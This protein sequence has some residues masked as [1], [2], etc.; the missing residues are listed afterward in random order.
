MTAAELEAAR[1]QLLV[2]REEI[3]Q[4]M[5]PFQDR[6]DALDAEVRDLD[7]EMRARERRARHETRK[8]IQERAKTGDL[9]TLPAALGVRDLFPAST[10]LAE[11]PCALT[12]GGTVRI[13]F[14]GKPGV[15]YFTD[16]TSATSVTTWDDACL[17][18][19][20][21]LTFG[22]RQLPGIRVHFV[23]TGGTEKV[24]APDDVVVLA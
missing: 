22:T 8:S 18:Y 12:T 3:L 4:A 6:L 24:V 10:P 5:A 2:R 9:P 15:L 16:G 1:K 20:R 19:A 14:A 21:G 13:G 23:D 17:A 11:V 7:R